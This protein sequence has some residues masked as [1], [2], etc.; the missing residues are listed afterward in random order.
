VIVALEFSDTFDLEVVGTVLLT[1]VTLLA[2]GAALLSLKQTREQISISRKE[3]EEAHRAAVVPVV[4]K[5]FID[6]PARPPRWR[7]LWQTPRS[8]SRLGARLPS[9]LLSRV[10]AINPD[11]AGEKPEWRPTLTDDGNLVVPV[12]NV[13]PG[14]AFDV[15][16]WVETESDEVVPMSRGPLSSQNVAGLGNSSVAFLEVYC[17]WRSIPNFELTIEYED[18]AG[19]A[20]KT[21]SAFVAGPGEYEVNRIVLVRRNSGSSKT[22]WGRLTRVLRGGVV[23]TTGG[24]NRSRPRA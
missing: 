20:W 3:V 10:T 23:R 2:V 7:A 1:F 4:R 18:A 12:E 13:G 6:L 21:I 22:L 19:T 8:R 5:T 9:S 24:Q 11:G 14:P 17:R 15:V 16:A